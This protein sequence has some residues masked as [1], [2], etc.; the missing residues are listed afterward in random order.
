MAILASALPLNE[1]I[2]QRQEAE[3]EQEW[4]AFDRYLTS[5]NLTR[6]V[7]EL[8]LPDHSVRLTAVRWSWHL[9]TIAWDRAITVDALASAKVAAQAMLLESVVSRTAV[10]RAAQEIVQIETD[11]KLQR[12]K[13]TPAEVIEK[14]IDVARF[15][16]IAALQRLDILEHC[17]D[18][19][20]AAK[21]PA[22]YSRLSGDE[23]S[24]LRRLRAKALG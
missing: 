3:N 23:L 8:G 9:R 12:C 7:Q 4:R 24:E 13:A 21:A 16:Q 18:P 6:V 17:N 20:L 11:K 15:A 22:D 1:P 2:W 10:A 5:R 14:P 19:E